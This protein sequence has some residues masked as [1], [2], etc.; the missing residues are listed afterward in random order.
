MVLNATNIIAF[1]AKIIPELAWKSTF[2]FNS[3]CVILYDL[4]QS[5]LVLTAPTFQTFHLLLP[6]PSRN[7]SLQE[8]IDL[9]QTPKTTPTMSS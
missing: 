3:C 2:I 6:W 8:R 4:V 1:R 5:L 7:T 9:L